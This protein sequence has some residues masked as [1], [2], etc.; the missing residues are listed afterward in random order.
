MEIGPIYGVSIQSSANVTPPE[1]EHSPVI[2]IDELARIGGD[3][4]TSSHEESSSG[5][6]SEDEDDA[7]S[8]ERSETIQSTDKKENAHLNIFA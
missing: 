7:A 8:D 2:D 5:M 1:K 6:E 3:A 4:Y